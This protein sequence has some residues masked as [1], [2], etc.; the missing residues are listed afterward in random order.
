MNKSILEELPKTVDDLRAIMR[1]KAEDMKTN[2]AERELLNLAIDTITKDDLD[3]FRARVI[4]AY[5]GQIVSGI[6]VYLAQPAGCR[7]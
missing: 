7:Q 1:R 5:I 6:P 4:S 2:H 3:Q